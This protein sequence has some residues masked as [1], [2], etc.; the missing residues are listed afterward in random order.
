V[1]C[2]E[3]AATAKQEEERYPDTQGKSEGGASSLVSICHFFPLYNPIGGIVYSCVI[4]HCILV[5][6]VDNSRLSRD[7]LYRRFSSCLLHL[8]IYP[9]N[10]SQDVVIF[11]LSRCCRVVILYTLS[12][13]MYC[14][15][16]LISTCR[17]INL[18]FAAYHTISNTQTPAF[19]NST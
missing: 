11:H 8:H 2:L 13:S 19:S 4:M 1:E 17:I 15:T 7:T 6:Y 9:R 14:P 10:T 12:R 18:L 16:S 3:G 5:F